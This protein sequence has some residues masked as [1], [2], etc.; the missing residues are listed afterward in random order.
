MSDLIN[1]FK[2]EHVRI[3]DTLLEVQNVG[4]SSN[5]GQKLMQSA[6]GY[7]VAHLRKE[8]KELYPVL[9]KAAEQDSELKKTLEVY[10]KDMEKITDSALA[11]FDKYQKE[12]DEAEFAKDSRGL[13][14]V[15]LKRISNEETVLYKKY[16]EIVSYY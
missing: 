3:T 9:W 10:A 6:K 2:D 13:M 5:A 16:N 15:L 7:L 14:K 4:I 11:F 8:D 12:G 1:S